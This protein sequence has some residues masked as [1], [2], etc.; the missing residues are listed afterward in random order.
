MNLKRFS[1]LLKKDSRLIITNKNIILLMLLPLI[2]AVLYRYVLP[3]DGDVGVMFDLVLLLVT[4]L[5]LAVVSSSLVGM[6]IAEEKEKK[7]L[8]TLMLAGVNGTEFVVSK[9]I[10]ILILFVLSMTIGYFILSEPLE[11]FPL[12]LAY[13]VP[14]TISLLLLSATI[15]LFAKNQQAVGIIGVP[16]MFVI[17]IPMFSIMGDNAFIL[18]LAKFIPSGPMALMMMQTSLASSAY[19]VWLG[20]LSMGIWIMLALGIYLLAYHYRR[21]DN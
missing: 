10:V 4:I 9:M 11:L 21:F 1:A 20:V 6:S 8:R 3:M 19:P 16:L 2:F 15:G 5:G 17:M 18:T 7:T 14:T 12:Y 13:L